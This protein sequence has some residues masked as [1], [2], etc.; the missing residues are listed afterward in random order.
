MSIVC[1]VII[2]LGALASG[3]TVYPVTTDQLVGNSWGTY[4][5][6]NG[7][8]LVLKIT[9]QMDMKTSDGRYL[10]YRSISLDNPCGGSGGVAQLSDIAQYE[11]QIR[12]GFAHNCPY[13]KLMF[14][15]T[16]FPILQIVSKLQQTGEVQMHV[17]GP[18]F[19]ANTFMFGSNLLG[20]TSNGAIPN[21]R[22]RG[23]W[24]GYNYSWAATRINASP[25]GACTIPSGIECE[26]C[27]WPYASRPDSLACGC[28]VSKTQYAPQNRL[29]IQCVAYC[30]SSSIEG[31]Q[32]FIDYSRSNFDVTKGEPVCAC[33]AP[34][35]GT[36]YRPTL[37]CPVGTTP[38]DTIGR[39]NL[40]TVTYDP[41]TKPVQGSGSTSGGGSDTATHS[42]LD[43]ILGL[44]NDG[45][46]ADS[47]A[48]LPDSSGWD[49]VTQA[50]DGVQGLIDSLGV[51]VG[52]TGGPWSAT[53]PWP[54]T[55]QMTMTVP[56]Y[57][58][59]IDT[60]LV[61][62]WVIPGFPFD[63]WAL[64]RWIEWTFVTIAMIPLFVRV[65]GGNEDT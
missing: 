32:T 29:A 48:G 59:V 39:P 45:R 1:A 4:R 37:T 33:S 43:S 61:V 26:T 36:V 58:T 27:S 56:V 5:V 54:D 10:L 17:L 44:I 25:V 63:L 57:G 40:Q 22:N 8:T 51:S 65:A 11:E 52:R 35:K 16:G 30:N 18:P 62:D 55:I 2:Y 12:R 50:G 14:M 13:E 64:F 47:L 7:D 38:L 53:V 9:N 60:A 31:T 28:N 41:T 21:W 19:P 23:D 49:S 3:R 46:D 6:L 20:Q 15:S 34:G 42:R 24:N